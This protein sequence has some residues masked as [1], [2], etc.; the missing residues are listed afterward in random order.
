MGM[1][2]E[3]CELFDQGFEGFCKSFFRKTKITRRHKAHKRFISLRISNPGENRHQ[4]NA[5]DSLLLFLFSGGSTAIKNLA[6]SAS[7]STTI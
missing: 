1:L 6:N 5:P 2:T 7:G 4:D 3:A